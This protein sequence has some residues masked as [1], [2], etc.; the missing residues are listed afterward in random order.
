MATH[1]ELLAV[2]LSVESLEDNEALIIEGLRHI[3]RIQDPKG[4]ANFEP[5]AEPNTVS[6]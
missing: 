4:R 6:I 1:P 5:I 2:I 3:S